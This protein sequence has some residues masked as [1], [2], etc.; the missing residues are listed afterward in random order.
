[1]RRNLSSIQEAG[2]RPDLSLVLRGQV[3]E[4]LDL[5]LF[6]PDGELPSHLHSRDRSQ[7]GEEKS[8]GLAQY[9]VQEGD[10]QAHVGGKTSRRM[11]LLLEHRRFQGK[12]CQRQGL[13]NPY[14][15]GRG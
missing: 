14:L 13:Q 5:A 4:R 8:D 2:N 11:Q 3:A 10:A 12:E 6:R 1:R 9:S 15:R 7:E